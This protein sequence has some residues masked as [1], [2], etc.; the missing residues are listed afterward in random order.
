[1]YSKRRNWKVK[2]GI[3]MSENHNNFSEQLLTPTCARDIWKTLSNL[4][5]EKNEE[6]IAFAMAGALFIAGW[7]E[8]FYGRSNTGIDRSVLFFKFVESV[9]PRL[10]FD[11]TLISL[12]RRFIN[13]TD[14][15]LTKL[16]ALEPIRVLI[17]NLN[18]VS[19]APEEVKNRIVR[20]ML[21]VRDASYLF[22]TFWYDWIR[23]LKD[24]D[25]ILEEKF[26]SLS[27]NKI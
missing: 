25:E 13:Y 27:I 14:S 20:A 9:D 1:M 19:G 26:E 10:R 16:S 6:R 24:V 17:H 22:I 18:S 23:I 2:G 11:K 5:N 12:S 15:K 3:S 21:K 8:G 7:K 4:S